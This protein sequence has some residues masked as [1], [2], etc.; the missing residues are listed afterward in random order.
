MDSF[1]EELAKHETFLTVSLAA[2]AIIVFLIILFFISKIRYPENKK[3]SS[4]IGTRNYNGHAYYEP[5]KNQR[6]SG[7]GKDIVS[8]NQIPKSN[9]ALY[10]SN[11]KNE[12]DL[13]QSSDNGWGEY[14]KN[15][16]EKLKREQ[17]LKND[18]ETVD[19]IFENDLSN[20]SPAPVPV[21]IKYEYLEAAN[22][23]QFRKL[24]P[25][26]EKCFFKTWVENGIRMFE[27]HG[28]VEKALANI[29]AIFDDVCEIEG[30]KNG[31]TQIENLDPGILTSQLK[32]DKPAKIKLK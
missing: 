13:T 22:S 27:F 30:K 9:Q 2:L 19:E 15:E 17:A 14:A 26:D 8:N 21:S 23:G 20:E 29:N 5:N 24:L 16:S 25:S 32:V 1:L 3:T 11:S 4:Y 6:T 31:A 10:K 28:N 7:R 18:N 12:H